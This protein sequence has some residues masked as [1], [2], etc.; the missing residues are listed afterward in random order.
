MSDTVTLPRQQAE[1]ILAYLKSF[2]HSH[3]ELAN[4]VKA[5]LAA[6]AEKRRISLYDV[7]QQIAAQSA[8]QPVKQ[9]DNAD[10]IK[11][12]RF[13]ATQGYTLCDEA[14]DALEGAKL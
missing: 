13:R 8:P 9:A 12:L 4:A 3:A 2:N 1:L 14:A 10:L 5:A 7:A 6:P 11:R